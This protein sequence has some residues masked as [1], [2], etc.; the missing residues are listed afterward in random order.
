[1]ARKIIHTGKGPF[2]VKPQKKSTFICTCGLSKN[3]PFCDSSHK[4][5][6]DEK[7]DKIYEYDKKGSR[8]RVNCCSGKVE[9]VNKEN[10][11]CGDGCSGDECC[12][13]K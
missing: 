5:T 12:T 13:E 6:L 1:M 7:D 10:C 4:K 8:T 3:Q 2:E 9:K 11:C